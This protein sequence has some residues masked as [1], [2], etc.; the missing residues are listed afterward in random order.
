MHV[1]NIAASDK[2]SLGLDELQQLN[3]RSK[4][5]VFENGCREQVNNSLERQDTALTHSKS[6][7]STLTK[8]HKLGIT[9]LEL[10][11]LDDI[12]NSDIDKINTDDESD[13]DF[14]CSSKDIKRERPVGLGEAM[15][16]IR[17]K[18]EQGEVMT[19][20][21]RR[22]ERKQEI[23]SIRSRLFLG[24]QAKIKEMY[25]LA[26]AE[27]EQ[28][29]TSVGKTPD[30]NVIKATHLIKDR[31][32]K[33]EVF[34]DNK[35]QSKEA[36]F[37]MQADADVFESGMGIFNTNTYLMLNIYLLYYK[38]RNRQSITKYLHGARCQY[39]FQLK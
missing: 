35:V 1:F 10:V 3:V 29:V 11:E 26:V 28:S 16:D 39:K 4:F 19:K 7:R 15:N 30:I 13:M 12:D 14:L 38:C 21:E 24:K 20:E 25:Q 6:I 2:P 27:S 31:F 17:S 23:Q 5:K 37:G 34:N 36:I 22:E 18:F 9:N 33:G 8:L 32:E